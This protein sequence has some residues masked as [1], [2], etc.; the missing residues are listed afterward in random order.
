MQIF[1]I[2]PL[3]KDEMSSVDFLFLA[4]A[5]ILFNVVEPL[6]PTWISFAT[7]LAHFDPEVILLLQSKFLLKTTKSLGRDVEN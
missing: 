7:I 4:L 5:A 1:E 3:A 6:W 2:G